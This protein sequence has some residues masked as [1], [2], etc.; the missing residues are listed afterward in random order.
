MLFEIFELMDNVDRE[1]RRRID[2]RLWEYIGKAAT[3]VVVVWALF[4]VGALWASI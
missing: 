3:A 1:I 4:F 2:G